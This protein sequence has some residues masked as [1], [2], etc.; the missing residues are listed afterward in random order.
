MCGCDVTCYSLVLST[1][2]GAS[3]NYT[4]TMHIEH[5]NSKIIL[6]NAATELNVSFITKKYLHY[7]NLFRYS[8]KFAFNITTINISPGG[9]STYILESIAWQKA[10]HN[11][12]IIISSAT[13]S[14]NIVSIPFGFASGL[15]PKTCEICGGI[16]SPNNTL[17]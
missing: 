7:E 14:R 8:F 17:S 2:N 1:S 10:A 13:E 11:S 5:L 12:L 4:Q 15:P 3:I 16:T 9:R 6:I